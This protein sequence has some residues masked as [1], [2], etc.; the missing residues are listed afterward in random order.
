MMNQSKKRKMRQVKNNKN[1]M[2]KKA[3]DDVYIEVFRY[4]NITYLI[5]KT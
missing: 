4:K 3:A 1:V 5:S 2:L